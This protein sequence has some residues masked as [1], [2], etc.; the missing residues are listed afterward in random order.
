M[1]FFSLKKLLI[2]NM[3]NSYFFIPIFIFLLVIAAADD[4]RFHDRM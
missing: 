4:G 3:L 2:L 1:I